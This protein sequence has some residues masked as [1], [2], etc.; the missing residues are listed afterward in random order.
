MAED[1][2]TTIRVHS[3][4]KQRLERFGRTRGASSQ[5]ECVELALDRA[6]TTV[7][8]TDFVEEIF[9]EFDYVA[10]I[11]IENESQHLSELMFVAHVS[12][13]EWNPNPDVVSEIDFIQINEKEYPF[14][15]DLTY[16]GPQ[17]FSRT[18]I[19][20]DDNIIGMNETPLEDGIEKT[21]EWITENC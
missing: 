11:A 9:D 20:A 3:D 4:N 5:D 19:F 16:D 12:A 18:T 21:R 6:E 14:R 10:Q 7:D 17:E 8:L 1:E 13:E 15:L 2:Y